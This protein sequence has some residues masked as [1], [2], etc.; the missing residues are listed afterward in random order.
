[1]AIGTRSRVRKWTV[2]FHYLLHAAIYYYTG[3]VIINISSTILQF[4]LQKHNAVITG[5]SATVIKQFQ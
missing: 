3:L 2:G 4:A 5:E 1:M